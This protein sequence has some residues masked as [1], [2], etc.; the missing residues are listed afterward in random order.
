MSKSTTQSSFQ[1]SLGDFDTDSQMD[2]FKDAQC[3]VGEVHK[4]KVAKAEYSK[5]DA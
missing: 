1:M 2:G 5:G 4:K 3:M